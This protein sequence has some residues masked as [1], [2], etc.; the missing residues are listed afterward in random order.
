MDL[1]GLVRAQII[2]TVRAALRYARSRPLGARCKRR[3]RGRANSMCTL[4]GCVWVYMWAKLCVSCQVVVSG[5]AC[6]SV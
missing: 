2:D 5:D 3:G 1:K 4:S 6:F